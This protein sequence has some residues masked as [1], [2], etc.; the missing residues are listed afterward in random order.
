MECRQGEGLQSV[1]KGVDRNSTCRDLWNHSWEVK[2]S[3]LP[4]HETELFREFGEEREGPLAVFIICR[5]CDTFALVGISAILSLA[6]RH[7][8]R[9]Y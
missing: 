9:G 7:W 6:S 5:F 1:S 2:K 8:H 4:G 3:D